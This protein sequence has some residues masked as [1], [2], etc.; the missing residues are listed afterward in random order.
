MKTRIRPSITEYSG[1]STI[2]GSLD[3]NRINAYTCFE[4]KNFVDMDRMLPHPF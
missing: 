4:C 2:S 3:Q 1:R